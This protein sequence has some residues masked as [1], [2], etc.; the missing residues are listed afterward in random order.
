MKPLMPAIRKAMV[1]AANAAASSTRNRYRK[2]SRPI[3][4]VTNN[5]SPPAKGTTTE[6]MASAA[7]SAPITAACA[8]STGESDR[9]CRGPAEDSGTRPGASGRVE[10]IARFCQWNPFHPFATPAQHIGCL[11][12]MTA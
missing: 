6:T 7:L 9:P 3:G 11:C 5:D 1:L 10:V 12:S 8:I 2:P 4:T